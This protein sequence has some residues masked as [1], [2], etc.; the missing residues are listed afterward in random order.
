MSQGQVSAPLRTHEVPGSQ[1]GPEA[2]GNSGG[3]AGQ[4]SCVRLPPSPPGMTKAMASDGRSEPGLAAVL[5]FFLVI[6]FTGT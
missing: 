2:V 1:A 6:S 4:G 3:W 5:F